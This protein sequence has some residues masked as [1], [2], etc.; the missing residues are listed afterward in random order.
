M[1]LFKQ[2][3]LVPLIFGLVLPAPA[4][5]QRSHAVAPTDVA[6]IVAAQGAQDD[7]NRARVRSVLERADAVSVIA[8]LGLD[9]D[10]I[11][12]AV[13][14]MSGDDLQ[15]A[16][17]AAQQLEEPLVGGQNTLVI[18]TTTIIIVL[19]LIILIVAIAD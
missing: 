7:A 8:N 17:D 10:R 11:V 19:V 5:A 13:D 15:R 9:R 14:L 12:R 2:L 4:F 18:S 3:I 16:A 6:A 1:R